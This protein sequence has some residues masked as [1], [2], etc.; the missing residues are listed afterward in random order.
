MSF[1]APVRAAGIA[2]FVAAA[3]AL[4][5]AAP[6]PAPA[7]SPS[8]FPPVT[9][10]C[11]PTYHGAALPLPTPHDV[12]G[13][14]P[15]TVD[16]LRDGSL[17]CFRLA[18]D[19]APYV[20]APVFRLRQGQTLRMV[21]RDRFPRAAMAMPGSAPHAGDGCARLPY[22]PPL[23]PPLQAGYQGRPRVYATMQPMAPDANLHMHG[24]HGPPEIDDVFKTLHDTP[25]QACDYAFAMAA[26]SSTVTQ[27]PP[28]TYWYHTHLHGQAFDEVSSGLAGAFIV[29]PKTGSLPYPDEVLLIKNRAVQKG[30]PARALVEN[31]SQRVGA[32]RPPLGAGA[33]G[34]LPSWNPFAPGAWA[35]GMGIDGANT[36]RC[37]TAKSGKNPD[38]LQIDGF[39][40]PQAGEN[41]IVPISYLRA[42]TR[43]L[44]RVANL[45]ADDF[46]NL[47]LTTNAGT[48]VMLQ[49]V[50]RDGHPVA[51]G[52]NPEAQSVPY[53]KL[54]LPPGGRGDIVV[55]GD[56]AGLRL[57]ADNAC[58][59]N[60]G[61]Y[62]ERRTLLSIAPPGPASPQHPL[63]LARSYG[64]VAAAP[65]AATMTSA[66]RF[67]RD[68]APTVA[69]SILFSQYD[70]AAAAPAW[71]I[72]PI[73]QAVL[74]G[75]SPSPVPSATP[76]P[77]TEAPF[78]LRPNAG[79][80]GRYLPVVHVKQNTVEEW[81]L[82]NAT[83]EIHAFH[84]HQLTFVTEYNPL[85]SADR[86]ALG[87]QPPLH[88]WQDTVSVPPG[89]VQGGVTWPAGTVQHPPI[90]PGIARIKIDFHGV[91]TGQFVFHCH[92][93]FH[94]D[95]G[96]MAIIQVDP[97]DAAARI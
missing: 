5:S 89:T 6:A 32:P 60:V 29:L 97:P 41:G 96:M 39:P 25:G 45:T 23:P 66:E 81:T 90:V 78:W 40:V 1:P 74:T 34:P 46:I 21:L 65:P 80:T 86:P 51:D 54:L 67:L 2:A 55:T 27:Q 95:H 20:E 72:T 9:G 36:E 63:V 57:I 61:P 75:S 82:V 85:E 59:G 50:G 24:W 30:T 47:A 15:F 69:R 64:A 13:D 10:A 3:G 94:E 87:G 37:K 19:P 26:D 52:P 14:R 43:K 33:P 22:E 71:Y 42:G 16:V 8:P 35:S 79:G 53:G 91:P 48:P 56:P 31:A 12:V 62:E 93:L 38:P 83:P 70:V 68:A 49:V 44:Y 73:G 11:R 76:L 7:S 58:T 17:Y 88:V 84:I 28:G 18:G 92:M 4:A 77:F